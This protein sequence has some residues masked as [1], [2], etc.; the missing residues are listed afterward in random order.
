MATLIKLEQLIKLSVEQL[1]NKNQ[2]VI[3]Y[4]DPLGGS[5]NR[6]LVAFQSYNSVIAIFNPAGHILYVNWSKWDYSKTTMKHLKMF[7]NQYTCYQYD[8]KYQFLN[9]INTS[10]EVVLFEE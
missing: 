7:I 4:N 3:Y 1:A 8:N 9:F 10:G 5:S 2:F 6:T